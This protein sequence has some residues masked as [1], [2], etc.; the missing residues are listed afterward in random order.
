[1]QNYLTLDFAI[2]AF[3]LLLT[4]VVGLA[5]S[6]NIKTMKEYVIG[7]RKSRTT[8]VLVATFFATVVGA[9]TVVST[10]EKIF[11]GGLIWICSG[12]GA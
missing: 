8:P 7:D 9:G 3:Y 5:T 2:V 12:I 6:R 11:A 1:M 4:L 10:T